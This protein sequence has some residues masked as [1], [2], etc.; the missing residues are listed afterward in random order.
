MVLSSHFDI[1]SMKWKIWNILQNIKIITRIRAVM[2]KVLFNVVL[3]LVYVSKA[4][5]IV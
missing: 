4:T 1:D 5:E 3:Y 2:T